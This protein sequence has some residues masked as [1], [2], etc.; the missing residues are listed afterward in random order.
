MGNESS[1]FQMWQKL[2]TYAIGINGVLYVIVGFIAA[3]LHMRMSIRVVLITIVSGLLGAF[4]AFMLAAV[5]SLI[6]SAI[7]DNVNSNMTDTEAAVLGCS[8]GVAV[9]MLN[10]GLLHRIL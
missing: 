2:I 5:P 9:T 3:L 6:I 10:A 4:V 8:Q 1:I 7:Y